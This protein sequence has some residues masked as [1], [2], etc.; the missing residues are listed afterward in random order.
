MTRLAS[1]GLPLPRVLVGAEDVIHGKPAPDG[2]LK[3]ALALGVDVA[4]AV[5]LEDTPAGAEAGRAAGALVIGLRTTFAS[6]EGC[7]FLVPD[8]RHIRV[9]KTGP[10]PIRLVINPS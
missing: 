2:Y 6:V 9:A 10:G 7:D 3:A 8:L 5:V 1:V 4:R